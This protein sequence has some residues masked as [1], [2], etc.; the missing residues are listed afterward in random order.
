MSIGKLLPTFR[1][2]L[3]SPSS[4]YSKLPSCDQPTIQEA[5]KVWAETWARQ[6]RRP[7]VRI[8]FPAYQTQSWRQTQKRKY[9]GDCA[10]ANGFPVL[11][12]GLDVVFP[13]TATTEIMSFGGR[14]TVDGCLG[15]EPRMGQSRRP[16]AF[17]IWE[18]RLNRI[19][20]SVKEDMGYVP[21]FD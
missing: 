7:S 21:P 12:Q 14:K 16:K 5:K 17:P 10:Y 20:A 13:R 6:S 11:V 9:H 19:P 4:G 15:F 1:K 3:K 2:T 18:R 8:A